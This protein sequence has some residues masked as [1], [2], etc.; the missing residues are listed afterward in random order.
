M[1]KGPS[2]PIEIEID[3]INDDAFMIRAELNDIDGLAYSIKS[4]G[5]LEP[6]VLRPWRD[7]KY[8]LIAGHR[9]YKACLK[10]G[11]TKVK[12]I[13]VDVSDKDAFLMALVE[14]VQRKSLNP[15]EEAIAYRNYVHKKGWGG[16]SELAK[17]IGKSPSYISTMMRLLD[18]PEDAINMLK[19]GELKPFVATELERIN[20]EKKL[21]H[22]IN[23][24]KEKKPSLR[25][26]RNTI[27]E[28]K[29]DDDYNDIYVNSLME[30]EA[31]VRE[32]LINFDFII[33]RLGEDNSNRERALKHR[34]KLH[35]VLD[36]II[37]E[38]VM[39][40]RKRIAVQVNA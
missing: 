40:T 33:D 28:Y 9:R 34:Y 35:E 11:M 24:I 36:D 27:Y 32:C 20:D 39:M 8:Q 19:N 6:L 25:E 13:I 4:L 12:A 7:G 21:N 31:S 16:V 14:N 2:E 22:I 30:M 5:L 38:K 23:Y 17:N 3:K 37:R 10:A 1:S 18:L 15:I 29:Y 26:L